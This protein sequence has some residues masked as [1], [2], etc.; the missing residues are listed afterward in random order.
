MEEHYFGKDIV[1]TGSHDEIHRIERLNRVLSFLVGRHGEQI[2]EKIGA[3]KDWKGYLTV[4]WLD[5]VI[6]EAEKQSVIDA[7]VSPHIGGEIDDD[8]VKFVGPCF[9]CNMDCCPRRQDEKE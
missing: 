5:P 1:L 9:Y 4:M 3:M 6:E 7:W 8:S 2:L